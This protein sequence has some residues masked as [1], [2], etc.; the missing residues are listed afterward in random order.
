M[1]LVIDS[2]TVS[3]PSVVISAIAVNV[4]VPTKY[5]LLI[6]S[7]VNE[8]VS[9]PGERSLVVNPVPDNENGTD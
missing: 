2:V 7:S 6:V 9:V 5:P 1:P 8:P 3:S 4:F